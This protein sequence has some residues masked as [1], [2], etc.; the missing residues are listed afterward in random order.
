MAVLNSTVWAL[1]FVAIGSPVDALTALGCA[2]ATVAGLVTWRLTAAPLRALSASLVLLFVTFDVGSV[3][4]GSVAELAWLTMVPILAFIL[5]GMRFGAWWSVATTINV[6]ATGSYLYS[7]GHYTVAEVLRIVAIAPTL[8]GAGLLIEVSRSVRDRQ[9]E[10]ARGRA[11]SASEA[12]NVLLAKVSHEIRTPLNGVLGLAEGLSGRQL[13]A[14]VLADLETIRSSGH[15]LLGLLNE[16]LDIARAEARKMEFK[17]EVVDLRRLIV[18]VVE[19]HSARALAK[20]LTL[21]SSI[22]ADEA[23]WITSDGGRL[24]QVIGNLVSNG[25]KFTSTGGVRLD[26][27]VT[28]RAGQVAFELRV[29]DTGPG[30]EANAL[31]HVFEP[32]TQFD[33]THAHE[34]SGL[35]LA[36]AREVTQALGGTLTAANRSEGGAR[37]LLALEFEAASAPQQH[38]ED[39]PLRP[40]RALVVDDNAINR[41]VARV[42]LERLGAS[43]T[44]AA[45]GLEALTLA[46]RSRFDIIFLDLQMPVMDGPTAARKLR[47]R[48]DCTPIVAMTASAGP[49][50]EAECLAGGMNGCVFKPIALEVLR[51]VVQESLPAPFPGETSERVAAAS[52]ADPEA[53]G[54]LARPEDDDQR[55]ELRR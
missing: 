11:I 33:S 25:V 10:R 35:G 32:F 18:E 46:S 28:V 52:V 23:C 30:L 24:R 54:A 38:P 53:I 43:V 14:D 22:T 27:H 2:V 37:F 12:K 17:R 19:L 45:E 44:D 31:A 51:A 26:A 4:L 6:A 40:F 1:V 13:P 39:R 8:A 21:G 55:P 49:S 16:L 5:G 41:R 47:E 34:G 36:I 20:G 7:S 3:A 48:G 50:V 9:L 29:D 15:G 42:L